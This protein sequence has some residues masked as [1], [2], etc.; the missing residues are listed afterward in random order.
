MSPASLNFTG[1]SAPSG[2]PVLSANEVQ[3][4]GVLGLDVGRAGRV[5][6]MDQIG[7]T[8]AIPHGGWH[9]QA[10]LF[11][12]PDLRVRWLLGRLANPRQAK[13]VAANL[14]RAGRYVHVNLMLATVSAARESDRSL[15]ATGADMVETFNQGGLDYLWKQKNELGLPRT[16]TQT[17]QKGLIGVSPE[18][19]HTVYPA[20]IP[21]HDQLLA[22]AAQMAASFRLN[23]EANVRKEL[24][25]EAQSALASASRTALLV[26]QAYA[27]LAP[28]GGPYDPK[29]ALRE[30][31]GMSFGHRSALSLYAQIARQQNRKPTLDDI[32]TDRTLLV[33]LEWCHSAK[34]RAAEALFMERLLKRVRERLSH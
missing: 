28:G 13:L 33:H 16:V 6:L 4:M 22:Y 11:D 17:W 23:F 24:G 27:F 15:T 12:G 29:K 14:A 3:A 1:D 30:Q 25:D 21:A 19:H 34:T 26:W 31:L 10:R 2:P 32:V 18:S 7:A 5:A 8:L 9:G 20:K